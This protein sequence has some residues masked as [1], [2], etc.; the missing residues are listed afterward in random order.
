[1][2]DERKLLVEFVLGFSMRIVLE[3]KLVLCLYIP[4]I[5]CCREVACSFG[6]RE[7]EYRR[8]AC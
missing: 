6:T 7:E 4:R 8:P 3:L 5:L 1:M 2:H